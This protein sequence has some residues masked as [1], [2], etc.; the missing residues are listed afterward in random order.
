MTTRSKAFRKKEETFL[1]T[2]RSSRTLTN[3]EST[4]NHDR[5]IHAL[6]RKLQRLKSERQNLR[7]AKTKVERTADYYL[8]LFS[9]VPVGYVVFDAT[10][11]VKEMNN[12]AATLLQTTPE[13]ST[14]K[15]FS[16]FID[17]ENLPEFFKHLQ[18]A[19]KST[20]QTRSEL[21]L[22]TMRGN[23]ILVE[24][25]TKPLAGS[26]R[27]NAYGSILV[28]ITHQENS[29]RAL[30]Q[31]RKDFQELANSIDGIVWESNA[32]TGEF[33]FVSRQAERILGFPIHHWLTDSNFLPGR[34]HPDDREGVVNT[35]LQ[36]A[37]KL[38]GF[39]Q[40]FRVESADGR[41]LWMRDNVTATRDREGILKF[42]GIM[43]NITELKR[44]EGELQERSRVLEIFNRIGTSLTGEL[45]LQKLVRLVTE[46]GKEITGASFGA[47]S[48]KQMRGDQER[49]GLY[50]TSGAPK[51]VL[52]HL[53]MPEHDPLLPPT[54]TEKEIIR[55]DDLT[56][57]SLAHRAESQPPINSKDSAIRSYLAVPVIS[58][59]GKALGGLLF[60][61]PAPG[62]F[63]ER[64]QHLLVGI[65]AEAGIAL[66][67]A[68][69]Y[70][71]VR[72]SEAHFRE[73]ADAM[74]Q[75]VWVA[76]DKGQINYYNQ[77]WS[78][79]IGSGRDLL[80]DTEWISF[81]HPDDQQATAEKWRNAVETG[82]M[83]QAECR[84]RQVE[85]GNYRWH[86]LRA[87][88]IPDET[89]Q[90]TR[91]FGTF[92]DIEDQKQA[93]EK[94]RVLNT[95]LEKR[96]SERTAQL[97]ASNQELEA[98]SYSVSHDLRAPLRS[99]NAFSELVREDYGDRLDDQG[100][101]YLRIVKEA[102]TQMGRLIDD[103]L[104]L[105][106]V[107]RGQA[108]RRQID[109]TAIVHLIIGDLKRL[110][111]HREVEFVI[112]PEL[113]ANAD[114]R[115]MRIA[116]ENLLNNA[117]KFT[118]K[119]PNARIEVGMKDLEGQIVFFVKDN[120]AGFDMA[121]ADRLFGAFQRLHSNADFPGHG[122]GLATVQRIITRHGG[123]IWAESAPGQGATFYFTLPVTD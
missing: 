62:I 4:A 22:R 68:R 34:I 112:A 102:S 72:E 46:A 31:S 37:D 63:T 29:Q 83:F 65:A 103:L 43:M 60:G 107:T 118:G 52:M 82:E 2:K 78:D 6:E 121:F 111:P 40:E 74:P 92:T 108:R 27:G 33:T 85:T 106:R 61:H 88:P 100:R 18:L 81:L 15:N 99:I 123:R 110:E 71:A 66:D 23:S 59:S 3:R 113:K 25:I 57:N 47:F 122:V 5:Q 16:Q 8:S 90:V 55:I 73:L 120:G 7:N 26:N 79:F 114:E 87:V 35:R 115:L 97:Q 44:A 21:H 119:Q 105:S 56:K 17:N 98:F 69:L 45:D 20:R 101:Q 93:E 9:S 38:K 109:L 11:L 94:V 36:Q 75:I 32:L 48:Y 86:L 116:L 1:R 10:G 77:R 54:E 117:W 104:H 28:D 39:V 70:D 95:V 13:K 12:A 84:L 91:W 30:Q 42:H 19:R 24:L 14:N 64:A 51:E 53:P 67:N 80:V 50:S 96:V 41:T 49:F 58:R 89:G 76:D